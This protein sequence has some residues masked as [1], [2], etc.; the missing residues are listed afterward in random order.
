MIS[1]LAVPRVAADANKYSRGKLVVVAGSA[2]Y[3]GAAVL[4][5]RAGQRMGA[6]YTQVV[7]APEAVDIVRMS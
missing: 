3:P 2:R 1:D 7:C 5:A 6:G 4:A